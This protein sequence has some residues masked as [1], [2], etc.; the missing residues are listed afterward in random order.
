MESSIVFKDIQMYRCVH[1]DINLM[2]QWLW[3]AIEDYEYES[4]VFA[5]KY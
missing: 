1:C 5:F 4:N 2:N 3:M